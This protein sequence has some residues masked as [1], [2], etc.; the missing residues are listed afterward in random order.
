MEG[1]IEVTGKPGKGSLFTVT[2]PLELEEASTL[3]HEDTRETQVVGL[4]PGQTPR[5]ILVADDNA[6]N[7]ALLT[8]MLEK[9]GFTVREVVNGETAIEVFRAWRPHLICMDMRMPVM[10]GYTATKAIRKLAGGEQVKIIAVTASVFEEQRDKILGA[11][12]DELVCKP[13]REGEIF[14]AI[15]R[16]L[17]IEYRY[18]D[19]LQSYV[20]EVGPELT[21]EMLSE[22]PPELI[23]ELR[24]ATLVLDRATM[25]VL[26]ERIE[27][28][29]PDTAKG[30][31]R[32]V[33]GFKL[34][35]IRELLGDVI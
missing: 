26:V 3:V 10:D 1:R 33:D 30:L 31:Q 25:A 20:P 4:K 7:R 16:Q 28:H 17:G 8:M 34:E 2:I 5:R 27:A 23:A 19:T 18:A 6:D 13:V 12:C 29:A 9:V 35:R 14:D 11:G 22:L 15:G 32:L 24:H 21:G